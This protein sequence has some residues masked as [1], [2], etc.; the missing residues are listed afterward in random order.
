MPTNTCEQG[1]EEFIE[2]FF[3]QTNQYKK[4][5]PEDFDK[6]L[7]MDKS[8]VLEFVK[9]TQAKEWE[10]L[11]DQHGKEAEKMFLERLD[12]EISSRGILDVL[13]TGV[14]DHGVKIDM[15]Y[16]A[17][18]TKMNPEVARLYDANILSVMR[19]V[20][21]D[22]ESEKSIDMVLFLNGLPLFTIELKNQL[23]GQSV[24]NG[25]QQYRTDR[26][27]RKKLLTFK[28]CLAHFAI[29]TEQA[30]MTT[31][32]QGLATKFLPFNKGFNNAAG[33]PQNPK[34]YK[35]S[36]IWEDL[37]TK[38]SVL[39]T[40]SRFAHEQIEEREDE[41][42]RKRKIHT[43]IFPRYHQRNTVRRLVA[44]ARESGAGKN[45][46]IQHSAGSGKSNTIAWTAHR[47]A[48]LQNDKDEKVFDSVVV[49][50]DRRI[51]DK[52][53]RDTVRQFEQTA[54]VVVAAEKS[55]QELKD[56][57]EEG[58]K[59]IITTLQKF[60]V[61]VSSVG[62]LVGKKFAVI[63]DEAHSSQSGDTSKSLKKVLGSDDLDDAERKEDDSEMP[64]TE[65][66][67]IK[68]MCA[69]RVK[70]NNIS[71]FAFTATPK[72]K[73]LELFGTQDPTT[74]KFYS[75]SLYSMKQAIEEGFILDTLKNYTTYDVYFAL[76]K[77]VQD[78]P[79][80]QKK[81][82]QRVILEYVDKHEHAI[83]KKVE[84]IVSHFVDRIAHQIDG[85]AKA[86]IVTKSRKHAVRFKQAMDAYLEKNQYNFNALVAFS[87]TVEDG[88]KEYTE[89]GMNKFPE[90]H[91]AEEFKKDENKFLIVAEKFQ[92]GFDQPLLSV[93]YVD[94]KLGG[95]NAV[96][97]LSR[98]NRTHTDK[99][100]VFVLDFVN[101]TEHIK[102]SFEPYYK[103]TVLS[104]ATD[105]N[106]LHDIQQQI[107]AFK[108][109]SEQEVLSF[110]DEYFSSVSPDKLNSE[111]DTIV[112]R[113]EHYLDE[114]KEE[115]K[116]ILNDYVKKYAFVS[117][118]ISFEDTGLEKLYVFVRMLR[119]KLPINK[120]PLPYELLEAV[121]MES[122]KVVKQGSS[123][124]KLGEEEGELDP[125]GQGGPGLN[126]DE[127]DIL[128]QIVKE[129]NERFGTDFSEEDRVILN[130]LYNRLLK[131]SDLIGAMQT[132]TRDSAKLKFNT[133]FNKELVGMLNNH[134]ELYKKL[135]K[136][137][138]V[139][140]FVNR[141]MFDFI[142]RKVKK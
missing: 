108:L 59:I 120:D 37:W 135:D 98:L 139:K 131:D 102:K 140:D 76:S 41:K 97:T 73:T 130:N 82:A 68:E 51:L 4:Q 16:F 72:Q 18:E 134:F 80:Y 84:I 58:E 39:E 28:R 33:N 128:S 27:P 24:K 94:K 66:M 101:E 112:E 22:T 109:F 26:D 141:R 46:L 17:P 65:D 87:G 5:K 107:Y 115:F 63:I 54:G 90:S 113:F 85:R 40:V 55:S 88:G 43:L 52:Q 53:L 79:E 60:P 122:Y 116:S 38:Q 19:Q 44:D 86:M 31:K 77:H 83:A 23:T 127:A 89:T 36:Y 95:V 1:F 99:E 47:L 64:T 32:L 138:D 110:S 8:L 48:E 10:K 11:E 137:D 93:M 71:F 136:S 104:Q 111:L 34:G 2:Q 117:Q 57:L 129:I 61:I 42:G 35:T 45:Y 20:K 91:T 49:V 13:R 133:V 50:T 81:K 96:Q 7:A 114:E 14:R 62:Q 92:T 69:R 70:S 121:D 106:I 124:I 125:L 78:D 132:N 103:T 119:K 3:V 56:A 21:F 6:E 15:A 74:G 123:A 25:T 105:P 126:K 142:S 12:K 29:D 100:E 30:Y 118:I 75:F 67:V 9:N